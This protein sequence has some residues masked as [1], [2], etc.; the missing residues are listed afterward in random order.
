MQRLWQKYKETILYIFFGGITTVVSLVSFAIFNRLL[1]EALYQ[2]SNVISWVLAVTVAYVTNKLFVFESKSWVPDVL[3]RELPSFVGARL[4]SLGV[5]AAGMFLFVELL[6][7][8]K[9]SLTLVGFTVLGTDISKFLMQIVV[10]ILNYV[11]S[12]LFIFKK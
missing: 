8:D 9:W 6:G 2:V 7:F 10:L 12:K 3:R 11:F 1:G 4:A 5:E